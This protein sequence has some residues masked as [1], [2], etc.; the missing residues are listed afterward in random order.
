MTLDSLV[1]RG[2]L[3]RA[4]A[5]QLKV[6]VLAAAEDTWLVRLSEAADLRSKGLIT[7]AEAAQL[8][9]SLINQ[10]RASAAVA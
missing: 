6:C 7:E 10:L 9:E 4:E 2:V 3:S 1:A 5:D 8:K